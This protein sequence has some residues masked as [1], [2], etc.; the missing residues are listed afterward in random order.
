MPITEDVR[1]AARAFL[2]PDDEIR[3][4]FPA[5]LVVSSRPYVLIVVSRKAVKVLTT[6]RWQ[7]RL[8]RAVEVEYPRQTRIGPVTVHLGA[9]FKLGGIQYE[10]DEEYVAVVNAADLERGAGELPP[11]PLPDL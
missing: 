10:L 11:D 8:P 1:A 9:T 7:G 3:Y 2:D 5:S 6:G 4:I